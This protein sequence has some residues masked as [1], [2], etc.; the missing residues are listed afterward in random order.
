M[1]YLRPQLLLNKFQLTGKVHDPHS[2]ED[3]NDGIFCP[4][5]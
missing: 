4:C 5:R 3:D 1:N 2:T